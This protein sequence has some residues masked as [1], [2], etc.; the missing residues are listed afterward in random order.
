[1]PTGPEPFLETNN[2]FVE[3]PLG[4]DITESNLLE[5][6]PKVFKV[7]NVAVQNKHNTNIIDTLKTIESKGEITDYFV[8]YKTSDKEMFKEGKIRTN[9]INLEGNIKVGMTKE[10]FAKELDVETWPN[11]MKF[12][13]T[14]QTTN[15]IFYF[16]ESNLDSILYQGYVD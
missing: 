10:D 14:E 11:I 13:N 8:I 5:N 3:K 2:S 15:W 1:M 7:T 6:F 9:R 12:C 16:S 4:F